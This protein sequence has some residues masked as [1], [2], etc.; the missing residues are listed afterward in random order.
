MGVNVLAGGRVDLG[1]MTHPAADLSLTEARNQAKA[2]L[3]QLEALATATRAA[4]DAAHDARPDDQ[5]ET[6][7]EDALNDLASALEDA[8]GRIEGELG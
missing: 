8:A 4:Y 2:L 3:A 1:M 7:E 6:E 5:E